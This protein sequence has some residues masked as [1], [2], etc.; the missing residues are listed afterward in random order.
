MTDENIDLIEGNWNKYVSLLKKACGSDLATEITDHFGERLVLA[1]SAPRSDQSGCF[2]GGLIDHTLRVTAKMRNLS[3]LYGKDLDTASILKVGLLHDLGKA[4]DLESDLF[5][6]QDSDWHREKLGQFYKYNED[7]EKMSVSH[8]TLYLLQ[9]FGVELSRDEWLAIQLA[10]GSHF[11]ENRFYVGS[12]PTLSLITQ[13][14]KQ[15]VN[16]ESKSD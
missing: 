11:E 1:P 9:H 13:Q 6:N 14:A 15:I 3:K 10:Q 8:R 5:I 4:G 2:P 16:H 7:L 12:E